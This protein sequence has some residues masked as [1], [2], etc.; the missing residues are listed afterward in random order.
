MINNYQKIKKD[1][2]RLY[3]TNKFFVKVKRKKSNKLNYWDTIIDPDG[4]IRK[5]I[6][7]EDISLKLRQ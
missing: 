4:N 6:G 2:D 1:I 3:L 7:E 5:R